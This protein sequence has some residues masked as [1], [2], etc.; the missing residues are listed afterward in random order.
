ML[1][2][3]RWFFVGGTFLG[4]VGAIIAGTAQSIPVAIGG[5]TLIGLSACTGYSYAF[6]MG[7]IVPVK[8]RFL[9]NAIV[10]IFSLPTAGFGA[11]VSTALILY[12]GPSWR[13]VYYLLIILNGIACA[14]YAAFYFPP[15]FQEKHQGTVM[16]WVKDFDYLGLILFTA[17]L[18][19]FIL[20]LSFGGS[21]YPWDSAEVISFIV[22]GFLCLIALLGQYSLRLNFFL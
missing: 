20:G 12:T 3:R 14:L 8:Y 11:A 2:G 1:L 16:Q 21:L 6:V 18:T 15:T 19:L 22:I 9:A 17:G 7:E 5:Q 4:L 10:F 13:W